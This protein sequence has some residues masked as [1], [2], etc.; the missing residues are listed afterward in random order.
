MAMLRANGLSPALMV[1]LFEALERHRRTR[2]EASGLA[3]RIGIALS[4]HPAGEERMRRF[5]EA[6]NR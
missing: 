4:S 5:R 3:G 2:D 1:E 6:A